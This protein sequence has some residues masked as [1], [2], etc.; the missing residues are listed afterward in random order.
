MVLEFFYADLVR[1]LDD[2]SAVAL[3]K[4]YKN[5]RKLDNWAWGLEMV[6]H[7][8]GQTFLRISN[9]KTKK[10]IFIRKSVRMGGG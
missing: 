2:V 7:F 1:F 9:W 10:Y 4:E 6:K 3:L 8:V 5:I